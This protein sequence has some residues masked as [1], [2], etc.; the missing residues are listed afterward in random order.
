VA[1]A[2]AVR[3]WKHLPDVRVGPEAEVTREIPLRA[4]WE[5]DTGL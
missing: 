2:V 1:A 4:K 5:Q 3:G